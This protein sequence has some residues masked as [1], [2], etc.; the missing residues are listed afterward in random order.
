MGD[1]LQYFKGV[2]QRATA[3]Y[4]AAAAKQLAAAAKAQQARRVEIARNLTA[5]A[6]RVGAG[7]LGAGRAGGVRMALAR[8]PGA[9]GLD[10]HTRGTIERRMQEA[11][12]AGLKDVKQQAALL[13]GLVQ[14][15]ALGQQ[16][17]RASTAVMRVFAN[18]P[19]N[20]A[21]ADFQ[22]LHGRVK[23]LGLRAR[24]MQLLEI[25]SS[26]DPVGWVDR[27][28]RETQRELKQFG[29][30]ARAANEMLV[31]HHLKYTLRAKLPAGKL[32]AFAGLLMESG[33][34]QDANGRM[35]LSPSGRLLLGFLCKS[36]AH[37]EK[38]AGTFDKIA[39]AIGWTNLGSDA[40]SYV[41]GFG[42]S[43]KSVAIAEAAGAFGVV[44]SVAG[45]AMTM[46]Q[47]GNM[48]AENQKRYKVSAR[49]VALANVM[50]T[51]KDNR[52]VLADP[53]SKLRAGSKSLNSPYGEVFRHRDYA[54]YKDR[55]S[56]SDHFMVAYDAECKRLYES[57]VKI[58][59][60]AD[61]HKLGKAFF[62]GMRV[63]YG[64][65]EYLPVVK[66][67]HRRAG[68]KW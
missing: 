18:R 20:L 46:A 56:A 25:G 12:G 2:R 44:L 28:L 62:D 57:L 36:P 41:A 16:L 13:D 43:A 29:L 4:Q 11:V 45:S 61:R 30:K 15:A 35:S 1:L 19:P 24:L 53:R 32:K 40:V 6:G 38:A 3:P 59:K 66:V 58:R 27:E 39:R 7:R 52:G 8:H 67:L 55:G 31:T 34:V 50:K 5:G 22:A 49:L 47:I 48:Q 60:P 14:Y 37:Y 21:L 51:L 63:L 64:A 10:V 26:R 17:R 42:A 54:L 33:G 23:A 9:Q 68:L 65:D